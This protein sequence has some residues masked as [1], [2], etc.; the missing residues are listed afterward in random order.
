MA[1]LVFAVLA[2]VAPSRGVYFGLTAAIVA[3]ATM[4]GSSFPSLRS[5]GMPRREIGT[6]DFGREAEERHRRE[7]GLD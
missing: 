7:H 3:W 2:I 5:R 6:T 4:L 1:L